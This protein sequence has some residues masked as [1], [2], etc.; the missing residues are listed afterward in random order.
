MKT[1][2]KCQ[3]EKPLIEFYKDKKQSDGL[4]RR[5]KQCV[6]E[7]VKE[8]QSE[9]YDKVLETTRAYKDTHLEQYAQKQKEYYRD[10]AEEV[11]EKHKAYEKTEA[12]RANRLKASKKHQSLYRY[13]HM[14]RRKLNIALESG[15]ILKLPCSV[16][17]EPKSEA[18]HEDYDKPLDVI[19]FCRRHHRDHHG[20]SI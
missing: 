1:C 18:H 15:K 17:N 8:W 20:Y 2:S 7:H 3:I 12:G 16:C 14:A 6:K 19:W 10:H 5:C 9:N 4:T 11:K 13:K